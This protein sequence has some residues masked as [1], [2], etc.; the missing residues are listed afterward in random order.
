MGATGRKA[1]SR[2]RLET[3]ISNLGIKKTGANLRLLLDFSI[4][5]HHVIAI[6]LTFEMASR[7][8]RE[9]SQARVAISELHPRMSKNTRDLREIPSLRLS[10]RNVSLMPT[11]E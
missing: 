1:Q 8:S 6:R 4:N 10:E 2:L 9:R 3:R 7:G 11:Q 5:G